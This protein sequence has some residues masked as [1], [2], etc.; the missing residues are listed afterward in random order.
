MTTLMKNI[1]YYN[2][3]VVSGYYD[4]I[5]KKSKGIQSAWHHIKFNY[6]KK[7][8]FKSQNHLD[9]G[10]GP[11]TFLGILN[12]KSIGVDISESQINYAKKNYSSK[13]I[14]FLSYKNKIPVKSRSVDSITLIE[15]IEHVDNN[16]LKMIFK[17]C[18]RVLKDNGSL[19]V[20]T[21]NYYSLWPILEFFLNLVSPI[22][23]K[24]EHINKFNK[25]KLKKMMNKNNFK[26]LELNSFILFSP[27]LA[28]LSFDFAKIMIILD[29]ILTKCFPGFL[30]FAR[31]KKNL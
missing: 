8:L 13:K 16:D 11:G 1:D 6:I 25:K 15:L 14:K 27:F 31:V 2:N 23:Y 7:K 21:P 22:D 12:K 24:H 9:I 28:F 3:S 26:V 19:Y 4:I 29:N 30:L 17:E 5:F 18:N 10:C 20:T